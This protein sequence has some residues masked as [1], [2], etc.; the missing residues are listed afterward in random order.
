MDRELEQVKAALLAE[1]KRAGREGGD[2]MA[3]YVRDHRT[4]I[5]KAGFV[6][7]LL[8]ICPAL[9]ILWL[10]FKG[11]AIAFPDSGPQFR[12]AG[13]ILCGVIVVGLLGSA[14]TCFFASS[15]VASFEKLVAGNQVIARKVL[16]LGEKMGGLVEGYVSSGQVSMGKARNLA[17]QQIALSDQV[18]T[19]SDSTPAPPSS[20]RKEL[21]QRYEV[22]R[23]TNDKI[24]QEMSIIRSSAQGLLEELPGK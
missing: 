10:L 5:G 23:Q 17:Q 22:A 8:A 6:L 7:F 11:T 3:E 9:P 21:Y 1:V 2:E 20:S 18:L 13:K 16:G 19:T 14:I 24:C 12:S 15:R 4:G